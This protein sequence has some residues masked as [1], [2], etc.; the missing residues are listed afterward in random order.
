MDG[1]LSTVYWYLVCPSVIIFSFWFSCCKVYNG[2]HVTITLKSR[3]ESLRRSCIKRARGFHDVIIDFLGS[4]GENRVQHRREIFC[5]G[6]FS[7][8]KW[9]A[10]LMVGSSLD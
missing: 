7:G 1:C 3:K 2:S 4:G 8:C 10:E 9:R 5:Y 6:A